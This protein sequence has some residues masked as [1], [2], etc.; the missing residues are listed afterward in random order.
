MP[1][2]APR[3]LVID[4]SLKNFEGHYFEYDLAVIEAA[5]RLGV[6]T[7]LAAHRA[8]SASTLADAPVIGR[9]SDDWN[10]A[11]RSPL[12]SA[13]R[14]AFSILP[15]RLRHPLL[16]AAAATQMQAGPST[17]TANRRF[18]EALLEIIAHAEL[19]P[20]DHVLIHTLGESELLG[21]GTVLRERDAP[22]AR[23]H[24]VLRYDG[25]EAATRAFRAFSSTRAHLTFWTD[26]EQ[27]AAHYR[28][29]GAGAIGVLP[30]PHGLR[31]PV[32]GPD[33]RTGLLTIAYLGGARGDK[34]FDLLP[35][36]VEA[37]AEPILKKGRARFRIQANY[38]LSAEEPRMAEARRKLA[39][40]PGSWVELIDQPPEM[41]AFQSALLSTDLLLLPYR[42]DIY[43]RRSS[44]LLVQAMVAGIP[45]VVPKGTWLASEAPE[46]A[47]A[48]FG[49]GLSLIDAVQRA[50]DA[51]AELSIAALRAAPEARRRHNPELLIRTVMTQHFANDPGSRSIKADRS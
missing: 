14:R 11:G 23:L 19:E 43:R 48:A 36:L 46:D 31:D 3:L 2:S 9:F 8:Y 28:D 45:T 6:R 4:Q 35:S 30:I 49:E 44:G 41:A 29:L 40:F 37:M 17:V 12:R 1:S 25:T 32:A 39:R 10:T 33:H 18:A 34:G 7:A 47:H 50:V 22:R 27:L 15:A 26:T 51:H 20:E 38:A 21:L 16:K 5:T 42:S 13:L 24:I